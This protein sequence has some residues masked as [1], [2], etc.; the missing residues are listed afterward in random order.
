MTRILY[1]SYNGLLEPILSSQTI[2]YLKE[3][4]KKGFEFVLLTYEKKKD[5]DRKTKKEVEAIGADLKSCGI[6]WHYLVYH[7][8]PRLAA[9]LFDLLI[10][11][12]YSL[13]LIKSKSI[14]I[15]HARGVTPGSI[16]IFVSKMARVKLLFDMRGRLAEEMAAGG[17]WQEGSASFR[18]V[19]WAEKRLLETADAVT[20]L[21][22]K[23]ME[24]NKELDY[25]TKRNIPMDVIPCCV[26]LDKFNY[27]RPGTPDMKEI[28]GLKGRFVFTYSGKLGTFY[29]IDQMLEF[30]KKAKELIGNAALLILTP[31]D[32]T[33][34]AEKAKGMKI[35]DQ[36]IKVVHDPSFE[37]IPSYLNAS[38]A[39]V[40]FINS[41][42][43]LG[44]SP[45]KLGEF[46]ACGVPVV[47]NPGVGDSDEIVEKNRVGVVVKDF[48][49]AL[50][51]DAVRELLGLKKEGEALRARCRKTA[52]RYLSLQN[53]VEKYY[54]IYE[55][56]V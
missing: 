16:M 39:G 14:K 54:R 18:L 1:L 25:L 27:E 15:V 38:D 8:K 13:Y 50:Y 22:E 47:I 11:A 5:L 32:A 52:G 17:L 55:A 51:A 48:S 42:N 28:L 4:N 29:F 49:G 33:S 46:L 37:K 36:D 40:F 24:Y 23:H 41:Y 2:P 7:K 6:E 56:L 43:K 35:D 30:Y 20:V 10:G 45:I 3:L 44:S 31:D 9:T 19:K 21:T 12:L 53:G 34:V 26:D